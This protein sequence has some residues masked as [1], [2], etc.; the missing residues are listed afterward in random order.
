MN[1][2]AI[3]YV[4]VTW[5]PVTGCLHGCDYC[6]AKRLAETRLRDVYT[7]GIT[8]P[9]P[10][11]SRCWDEPFAPR[12]WSDRLSQ[13]T[14]R[15]KPKRVFVCDMGDLFGKWVPDSIIEQVLAKCR[16]A[17]QHTYLFLTKNPGRYAQI[18]LDWWPPN[19]WLGASTD[20][21]VRM[22]AWL[23]ILA[24]GFS[25]NATDYTFIPLKVWASAEP[26]RENIAVNL[27]GADLGLLDWLVIGGVT[28]Q[29]KPLLE[30]YW[31]DVLWETAKDS[32]VPLF[33]K[34]N[35]AIG[36]RKQEIP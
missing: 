33:V 11:N 15:Q 25:P 24:G 26:L 2:T 23:R 34:D 36:W 21:A 6:Y 4:D 3:E 19:T 27:R 13:P 16:E 30:T 29:Q 32:G 18:P 31:A 7:D 8:M 17:W 10:S 5:N 9:V 28:R 1:K 14:P 35:L 22:R 12:F 20:T